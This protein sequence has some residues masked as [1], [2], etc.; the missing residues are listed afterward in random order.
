MGNL[1]VSDMM[2]LAAMAVAMKPQAWILG[3][4]LGWF[5]APSMVRLLAALTLLLSWPL[6]A[7]EAYGLFVSEGAT[8]NFLSLYNGHYAVGTYI[9]IVGATLTGFLL[10][11]FV[12]KRL[13]A[14]AA[15]KKVKKRHDGIQIR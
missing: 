14:Q 8:Q 11:Y 5:A 4:V 9:G 12:R 15:K 6:I 3:A 2:W 1:M 13:M 7:F 10:I